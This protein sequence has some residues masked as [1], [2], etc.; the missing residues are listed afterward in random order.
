MDPCFFAT[1]KHRPGSAESPVCFTG[2]GVSH[3]AGRAENRRGSYS[4][5]GQNCTVSIQGYSC[6]CIV[7]LQNLSGK[8]RTQ[9]ESPGQGH[10]AITLFIACRTQGPGVGCLGSNLQVTTMVGADFLQLTQTDHVHQFFPVLAQG[11]AL[12]LIRLPENGV[13]NTTGSE[14]DTGIGFNRYPQY[15]GKLLA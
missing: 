13:A 6:Q 15:P 12:L 11:L 4:S 9:I 10:D 1:S 5:L 14:W 8:T 7:L 3:L 2:E